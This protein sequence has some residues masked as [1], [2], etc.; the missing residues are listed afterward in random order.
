MEADQMNEELEPA[1]GY[2]SQ[3]GVRKHG[4]WNGRPRHVSRHL[5]QRDFP[6]SLFL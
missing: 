4:R 5:V 2:P 6:A 3:H 1:V